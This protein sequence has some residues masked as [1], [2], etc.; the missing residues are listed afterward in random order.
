[1]C[2]SICVPCAC[3]ARGVQSWAL[4]LLELELQAIVSHLLGFDS[5]L[6]CESSEC[7]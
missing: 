5:G 2:R 4:D 3:N 1:M 6:I 7:P